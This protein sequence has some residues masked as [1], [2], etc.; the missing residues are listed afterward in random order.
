MHVRADHLSRK[1]TGEDP[2]G[3]EDDLPDAYLF[4][5]E[6]IPRWSE[7]IVQLITLGCWDQNKENIEN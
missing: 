2:T 5:I 6:I 3:V 1:I 7:E 4:N